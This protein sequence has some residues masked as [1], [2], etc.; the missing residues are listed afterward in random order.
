MYPATPAYSFHDVAGI[1][2]GSRPRIVGHAEVVAHLL[3]LFR[4][5]V[6]ALQNSFCGPGF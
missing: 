6:D 4:F 3:R 1:W 2:T 5:S